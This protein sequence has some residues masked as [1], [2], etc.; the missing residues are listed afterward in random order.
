[1][2]LVLTGLIA[3]D[4][5]G[6][7][8]SSGT[9]F[10]TI[11]AIVMFRPR[12]LKKAAEAIPKKDYE[13]K[14][15]NSNAQIRRDVIGAMSN[16]PFKIVYCTVNKNHPQNHR[17]I[18]GNELY[19]EV[20]RQVIADSFD[21]LPCRDV[22]VFLDGCPFITLN[23]FREIVTEEAEVHDANP[24]KVNKVTSQEN[25]CIQL[26]D[27][28]AGAVRSESEHSDETLWPLTAKISVARRR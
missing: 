27:F 24:K 19:E 8:G 1:M 4:E 6:D 25:K 13:V 5:S 20:L 9:V 22:N 14:W 11:A 21:V 28:V 18:Y 2:G 12:S 17:P 10:F 15:S 7:L 16:L 26:V 3:I 23:R